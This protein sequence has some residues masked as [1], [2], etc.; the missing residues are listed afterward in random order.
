[1]KKI[2]ASLVMVILVGSLT[3]SATKA[4]FSDTADLTGIT[5]ST[6]NA[7]IK[8]ANIVQHAWFEN[9]TMA[10]L[11]MVFP[12]N[13]YPGFENNWG[14]RAGTVYVGNFSTSDINL[15][16]N[17]SIVNYNED[18]PGLQDNI[19]LAMAWGGNCD[20]AG[21]GTGFHTLRWWRSNSQT[22]FTYVNGSADPATCGYLERDTTL[23]PAP[24][25][26]AVAFYLKVPTTVGNSFT[27]GNMSFDIHFDGEQQH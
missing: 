18:I 6:G 21:L 13:L 24:H 14:N 22:L 23:A 1:M 11:T 26:K 19:Q 17:A 5:F 8:V 25:A 9:P 20:N 10:D 3:T 7:D 12:Q 2:L 4:Y 27:G 16:V 15:I